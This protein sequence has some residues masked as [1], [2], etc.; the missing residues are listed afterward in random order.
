MN[1]SKEG[2][3]S[4]QSTITLTGIDCLVE[5][6]VDPHTLVRALTT[7]FGV[8]PDSVIPQDRIKDHID[9]LISSPIWACWQPMSPESPWAFKLDI[10]GVVEQDWAQWQKRMAEFSRYLS[11]PVW[12]NDEAQPFNDSMWVVAPDGQRRTGHIDWECLG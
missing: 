5:R 8:A 3:D 2:G 12:Y 7:C 6:G 11:T 1:K 9:T 10:D 4:Q